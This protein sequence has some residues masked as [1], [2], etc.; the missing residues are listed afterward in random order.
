MHVGIHGNAKANSAAKEA[1]LLP[2][3]DFKIPYTD[4]R[5]SIAEYV[6]RLWQIDWDGNV[7]CICR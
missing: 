3:T 7:Q 6:K 1:L 2:I 4:L 5:V